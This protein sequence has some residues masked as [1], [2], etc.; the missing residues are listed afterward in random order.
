MSGLVLVAEDD[1]LLQA[2]ILAWLKQEG[3]IGCAAGDGKTALDL[4]RSR[5]FDLYLLDRNMP[6]L[7]GIAVL[8][9][10]RSDGDATPALFLTAL[11]DVAER[12]QGL[13]AGADDYLTKPFAIAEL[14]ARV[15][16]LARRPRRLTPDRL[17]AG[18]V[19]LDLAGRRVFV[20]GVEIEVTAQDVVL[21]SVFLR[22]PERAFTREALLD[23]LIGVVD[24]ILFWMARKTIRA[25]MEG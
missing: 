13:D 22:H 3:L 2:F 6:V 19:E 24:I 11:G 21:L 18:A 9:A 1:D 16:A 4:A 10:L 20:A 17:R 25:D 8:K 5:T 7:D 15:R 23:R 12:V 14:M